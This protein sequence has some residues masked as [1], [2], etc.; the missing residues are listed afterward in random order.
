MLGL[1]LEATPRGP[2]TRS[3]LTERTG[4]DWAESQAIPIL[5]HPVPAAGGGGEGLPWRRGHSSRK[6]AELLKV[7]RGL[8]RAGGRVAR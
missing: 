1:S 8:P 5:S 6:A 2:G 7:V 4:I 3:L